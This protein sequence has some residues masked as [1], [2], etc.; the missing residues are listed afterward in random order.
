MK[1]IHIS[2]RL[3]VLGC[4]ISLNYYAL[5]VSLGL[6]LIILVSE[7]K[8]IADKMSYEIFDEEF[9]NSIAKIES[10]LSNLNIETTYI[11][12]QQTIN[13][14]LDKYNVRLIFKE[15]K[16]SSQ[17]ITFYYQLGYSYKG[18]SKKFTK[19]ADVTNILPE[20]EL[21]LNTKVQFINGKNT[22]GLAIKNPEFDSLIFTDILNETD[23]KKFIKANK[24]GLPFLLGADNNETLIIGDATKFPHLLIAGETNSGKSIALHVLLT[25]IILNKK[26]SEL[27]LALA[28]FKLVELNIFENSKYLYNDIVYELD[29]FETLLDS[30]LSETQK[31]LELFKQSNIKNIGEYLKTKPMPYILFVIEELASITLIDDK[32]IKERLENKLSVLA[33]KCRA[34]G[35]H[36]IITV[37]KANNKIISSNIKTNIPGRLALKV[38]SIADSQLMVGNGDA[39]KLLGNGDAILEGK[40]LQVAYLDDITERQLLDGKI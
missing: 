3:I 21:E 17:F 5:L 37:Q 4:L 40:R 11:D 20:L 32:E 24:N 13:K 30:L 23:Y 10:E 1:I 29:T 9:T 31:R 12:E 35:I 15:V 2:L 14:V 25:S 8:S 6:L 26:S 28:D 7:I 39:I 38:N 34:V 18:E 16:V 19:I 33:S 27:K 22:I 36:I